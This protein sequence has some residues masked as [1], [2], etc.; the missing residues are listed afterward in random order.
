MAF[1]WVKT[2]LTQSLFVMVQYGV[3]LVESEWS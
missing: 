3:I 2:R 1:E